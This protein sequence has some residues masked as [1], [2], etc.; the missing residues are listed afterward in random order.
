MRLEQQKRWNAA[1]AL[2]TEGVD[3]S[4][5]FVIA[6][7]E[8]ARSPSSRRAWIEIQCMMA[9]AARWWSPS[10]RRAWIEIL[11]FIRVPA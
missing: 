1:V 7:I 11:G 5:L 8:S 4:P 2:L 3:R 10:S 9:L 6:A